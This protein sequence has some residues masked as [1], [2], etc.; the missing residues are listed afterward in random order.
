MIYFNPQ[1]LVSEVKR[2]CGEA[3]NKGTDINKFVL[4][5]GDRYLEDHYSLEHYG[6]EA[7]DTI[8]FTERAC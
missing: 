5:H 3:F 6:V 7:G 1:Q 8:D 4:M 2:R